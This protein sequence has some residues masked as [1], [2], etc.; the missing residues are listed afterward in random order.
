MLTAS[1]SWLC[2]TLQ[3]ERLRAPPKGPPSQIPER[4]GSLNFLKISAAMRESMILRRQIL[5]P[6]GSSGKINSNRIKAEPGPVRLKVGPHC[7]QDCM[8][9]TA[10]HFSLGAPQGRVELKRLTS[11]HNIELTQGQ[12]AVGTQLSD[13]SSVYPL[14][15]ID[16]ARTGSKKP[17]QLVA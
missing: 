13:L 17:Q 3:V 14:A 11:E 8:G 1:D 9:R 10:G 2:R 6:N 5:A 12:S 15:P 7:R 4:T 16:N